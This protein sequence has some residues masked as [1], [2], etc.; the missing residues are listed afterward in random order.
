[1]IACLNRE[2]ATPCLFHLHFQLASRLT[3][4][5]MKTMQPQSRGAAA[6]EKVHTWRRMIIFR[7]DLLSVDRPTDRPTA[8]PLSLSPLHSTLSYRQVCS[9]RFSCQR[10]S[11]ENGGRKVGERE[12]IWFAVSGRREATAAAIARPQ[13]LNER[14]SRRPLLGFSL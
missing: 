12:E 7:P 11:D 14:G 5:L 8:Y 3:D 6:G 9:A 13:R 4:R 2:R 1:M 10:A